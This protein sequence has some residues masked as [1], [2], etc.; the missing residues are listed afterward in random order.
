MTSVKLCVTEKSFR[1]WKTQNLTCGLY[2]TGF[3]LFS[4][5]FLFTT[6]RVYAAVDE[7]RR[8]R[9]QRRFVDV[10]KERN[11]MVGVTAEEAGGGR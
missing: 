9:P 5:F 2:L 6:I 4:L 11:W 8:G 1:S 3:F 10:V 7:R